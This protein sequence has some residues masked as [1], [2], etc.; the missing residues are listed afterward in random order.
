MTNES[1]I[2]IQEEKINNLED[3]LDNIIRAAEEVNDNEVVDRLNKIS[4]IISNYQ[5]EDKDKLIVK[6]EQLK[7][8][9]QAAD[10]QESYKVTAEFLVE[11]I[12][13]QLLVKR[14]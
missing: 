3:E 2:P 12:R 8:V 5:I 1:E 10:F 4:N 13:G 9:I 6:L 7:K 11:A 14:I